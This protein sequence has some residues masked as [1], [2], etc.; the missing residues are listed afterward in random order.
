L[1]NRRKHLKDGVDVLIER[2][3]NMGAKVAVGPG[4]F[5]CEGTLGVVSSLIGYVLLVIFA[6]GCDLW[7]GQTSMMRE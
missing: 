2:R 3:F 7:N 1:L 4:K 6:R 5:L